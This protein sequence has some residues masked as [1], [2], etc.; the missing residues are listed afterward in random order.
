MCSRGAGSRGLSRVPPSLPGLATLPPRLLCRLSEAGPPEGPRCAPGPQAAAEKRLFLCGAEPLASLH[1]RVLGGVA[2][3]SRLLPP[4]PPRPQQ[5]LESSWSGAQSFDLRRAHGAGA[6][7]LFPPHSGHW[8]G[9][10]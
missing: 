1:E 3:V 10:S 8:K 7:P 2:D 5:T 4:P 9:N 6:L